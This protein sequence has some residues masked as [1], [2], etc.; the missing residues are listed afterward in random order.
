MIGFA[1]DPN[2]VRACSGKSTFKSEGKARHWA[3]EFLRKKGGAPVLYPYACTVCRKWHTTRRPTGLVG[4][5]RNERW[6]GV[7]S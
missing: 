4:I 2:V 3:H 6:E 7:M 1:S 5:T